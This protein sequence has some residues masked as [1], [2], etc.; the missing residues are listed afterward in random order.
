MSC[1]HEQLSLL[2]AADNHDNDNCAAS[3][4]THH[5]EGDLTMVVAPA[6]IGARPWWVGVVSLAEDTDDSDEASQLDWP[7]DDQIGGCAVIPQDI[8]LHNLNMI[9]LACDSGVAGTLE[10][11]SEL[12]QAITYIRNLYGRTVEQHQEIYDYCHQLGLPNVVQLLPEEPFNLVICNLQAISAQC[13]VQGLLLPEWGDW[14]RQAVEYID[15]LRQVISDW[16]GIIKR[17]D[18]NLRD[19]TH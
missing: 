3:Y 18:E 1:N 16:Q 9:S 5:Q 13:G 4:A 8:I 10:E 7:D 2:H 12:R 15:N 11:Q 17:L 14:C 6:P 19:G